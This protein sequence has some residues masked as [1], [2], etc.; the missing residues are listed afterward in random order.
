M[1]VEQGIPPVCG[2]VLPGGPQ[3]PDSECKAAG[4]MTFD[5]LHFDHDPPLTEAERHDPSKVCDPSRIRLLCGREHGQ[6]TRNEQME[7]RR[8]YGTN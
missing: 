4:L 5:D 8:S 3:V 2:A 7:L 6:K 1:L